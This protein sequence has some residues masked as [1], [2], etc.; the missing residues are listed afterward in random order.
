MPLI[1]AL[2]A[3]RPTY[4]YRRITALLNRQLRAQGLAPMNRKRVCRI[5]QSNK[6][7]LARSH[8]ER[9]AHTHDGKVIVI[10]SNLRGAV[11]ASSSPAGTATSSAAPSSST[12]VQE[13]IAWRVVVN[14][15]ISGSDARDMMLEAVEKRFGGYRG[16]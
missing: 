10:C 12:P 13:V 8:T 1:T 11:T 4:G 3:A 2:V 9:P 15:G 14:A 6:V 5:M 16:V 7:L